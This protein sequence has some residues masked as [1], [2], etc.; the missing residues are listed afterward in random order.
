MTEVPAGS[1][2]GP[3]SRT[4]EQLEAMVPS[5]RPEDVASPEAIV[6]AL[7]EAVNGPRGRWS[8]DRLRS[9]CVPN[10]LFASVTTDER[11]DVVIHNRPLNDFIELVE[12]I[13]DKGGWYERVT[14]IISVSTV[15]KRGGGLAVVHYA[16]VGSSTPDGESEEEGE[17]QASL[18]FDGTRWWVVSDTW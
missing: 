14:G 5:T 4:H 7:H 6:A 15:F 9:L 13:H 11:G 16:A 2:Y 17:T 10:V 8:S 1:V 12:A 3:W 18:M